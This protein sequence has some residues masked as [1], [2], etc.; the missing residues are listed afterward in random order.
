MLY[1]MAQ[2]ASHVGQSINLPKNADGNGSPV[3]K[4][5]QDLKTH[6]G[7]LQN[8]IQLSAVQVWS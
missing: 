2:Q 8:Q 3:L 1:V 4:V 7:H 6:H 5:W